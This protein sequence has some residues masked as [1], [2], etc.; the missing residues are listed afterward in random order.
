MA[1]PF[2]GVNAIGFDLS[3]VQ[4]VCDAYATKMKQ[5]QYFSHATA[6]LLF[7]AP[8]PERFALT[9]VHLSV[10]S[11]RT[12]PR[13]RAVVGH[14]VSPSRVMAGEL[15]GYPT[16][17]PADV[18]C[19]LSDSL[20]L[21]ELVAVGDYLISGQALAAAKRKAPLC[22][23]TELRAAVDRHR[24]SP[25]AIMRKEAIDLVRSGVDSPMESLLRI[26]LI[27]EGLPE[28]LIGDPTPVD[29][30]RSTLRPDLKYPQWRVVFEYEGETH[31]LDGRQWRLDIAR[32]ERLEA[33]D[34][35]VIRVTAHDLWVDPVGFIRRVRAIIARR[36]HME[37]A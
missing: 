30:G 12:A 28:P 23:V 21:A 16:L 32:R 26:L 24:W 19:Q 14:S 29:D 2:H 9:P 13:G 7:G 33:A 25:G 20:D 34:W 4:G 11:P 10:M 31:R 36:A 15:A 18:W 17:S 27:S 1:H 3:T 37:K 22:T 6:A 8:L 35:H 5:G